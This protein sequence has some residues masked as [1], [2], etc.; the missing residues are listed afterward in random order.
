MLGK[1]AEAIGLVLITSQSCLWPAAS[2]VAPA[3]SRLVC[4]TGYD[5][6]PRSFSV[7]PARIKSGERV[8]LRFK[9]FNPCS[10]VLPLHAYGDWPFYA[11]VLDK[12]ETEVWA[13]F[14]VVRN[15]EEVIL[16]LKPGETKC[17][18]R[19][20]ATSDTRGVPLEPGKYQLRAA[21]T[22]EGLYSA[23][24]VVNFV[25]LESNVERKKHYPPFEGALA[26]RMCP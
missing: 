9:V 26:W 2:P 21:L 11:A 3:V 7:V 20:W 16:D 8:T 15:L 18:E 12:N 17:F 22:T 13:P 4:E 25:V 6:L 5:S 10:R 1:A 23:G 24:K 14:R 19:E